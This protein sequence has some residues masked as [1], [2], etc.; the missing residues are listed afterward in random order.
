MSDRE[1]GGGQEQVRSGWGRMGER[2][3]GETTGIRR[4]L[5]DK[6]DTY[7][8]GNSQESMRMP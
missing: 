7:Y 4:H 6:V 8:N 1:V 3:L 5:R 2:V